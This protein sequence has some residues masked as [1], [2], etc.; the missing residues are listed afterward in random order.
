MHGSK[1]VNRMRCCSG[2]YLLVCLF[3]CLLNLRFAELCRQVV[4]HWTVRVDGAFLGG[5]EDS[6]FWEI[7]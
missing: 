6:Q 3:D 5:A 7:S 2:S 1:N 4:G